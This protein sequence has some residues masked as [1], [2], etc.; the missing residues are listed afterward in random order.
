MVYKF[1]RKK[2]QYMNF[3]SQK[4]KI[5]D[6]F[7]NLS[8]NIRNNLLTC[9]GYLYPIS[10]RVGYKIFLSYSFLGIPKIWIRNNN[11]IKDCKI[12]KY[13]KGELCLYYPKEYKWNPFFNIHETI[14]PWTA[15]WIV[16]FE[17]WKIFGK[18]GAAESPHKIGNKN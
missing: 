17:Y 5:E 12:H 15:E 9:S 6:A 8:V 13:K 7:P 1:S 16:C 4:Q 18:W 11:E 14:L 10:T 2:A 3:L